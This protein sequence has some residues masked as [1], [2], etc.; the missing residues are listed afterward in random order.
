[1][2]DKQSRLAEI[3]KAEKSK[4]GGIASTLG[5]RALEKIDPR[6][7]FNQKGF[8]AASLPSLFK[9]YSATPTKT[10]EKL[11]S[12]GGG[13]FSS[14]VLETKL[15]I[16]TGE[17]RELKVH[18]KLAAKNSVVLPSMA[19]DMNVTRQNIVKLVKLQGGTATTK[20]DMFFKRAGDREAGYESRFSKAG[21]LATKTPTQ[22]GAKPE[23]KESGGI[24]GFLGTIAS[25]LLK[26]GLLGLLAIG[27]G[28]LLENQDVLEGIKS[29]V[30]QVILGIQKVIQKGSE[31]LGDLFSDP[32]IKEGFIKTFV[33]VKDLFVK[34]INLLGDLAS[35]P[36][37]AEGVVQV[38]SAILEAIKK[39]FVSL[40]TYLKDQL[41]VPGGLLTIL[42]AGGA[43]YLA[44]TALGGALAGLAAAAGAAAGRLG[45]PLPTTGTPA[46]GAPAPGTPAPGNPNKGPIIKPGTIGEKVPT[47]FN[48]TAEDKIRERATRMAAEQ[49]A[50]DVAKKGAGEILKRFFAGEAAALL[51]GPIGAVW[52]TALTA[53]QVI[54][55]LAPDEQQQVIDSVAVLASIQDDI[56]Q[57]GNE[58]ILKQRAVLY[59]EKLKRLGIAPQQ[60]ESAKVQAL[61]S[62]PNESSA[63]ATRLA[64]AG[65]PTPA[66]PTSTSA[67]TSTKP[68]AAPSGDYASRIGGRES[69]GNYDTIFGKAGG[70]TINGKLVTENTIGEVATW[71]AGEREKKS[72]K[73]AAGKYQFM[74]VIAA[75]KLAG[76]GPNDLF[77]GPN[78]D[79]MMAAY[80]A[81]NAKQLRAYGLPDTEEYLSMAHAVGA[82]GAKKLIDAQNAGMGDANSLDVLGLE[83]AAAKTNPQLNTN[84]D[85]TIAALKG[86][87][88]MGHGS[89]T[90]LAKNKSGVT[91]A[92]ASSPDF[93]M[94]TLGTLAAAAPSMGDMIEAATSEF[95]GALRLFDS[96]LSSI[97]NI[98][99]NNTQ[100][101]AAGQQ[102]QGNLPSVY[103]DVF[104][105]LFQ[106]VT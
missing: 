83:G 69:G 76:L 4:G 32:E 38:F 43:L 26:G 41:N 104:L 98:T 33:A 82:K 27:V 50:K 68:T 105:N 21:G 52:L 88:P 85:T 37:F 39:A 35:D 2:A 64:A 79:K 72:N 80:T 25:Y 58:K 8:L 42:A 70:A 94:P 56:N 19:R 66:V 106:R 84:V 23:E 10:G 29:F 78:Q 71:Q 60:L 51:G 22:V 16:L 99:N 92:L 93:K 48:K 73:Q 101:S 28:K 30:K 20:A 100:A 90:M 62:A 55:A 46:P 1:M 91:S 9:S 47:G 49:G 77:N 103:D 53:Y 54:D 86:G 57:G 67:A 63:E 45:L 95:T 34:G 5:K 75:A 15:D 7:F 74:D 14:G 31:I 40:D 96:A 97:T 13:S 102:S 18:S 89:G 59:Q 61:P 44:I 24:L 81:E 17:T 3:Y 6:K 87:G 12:A 36:R 65:K 11:A